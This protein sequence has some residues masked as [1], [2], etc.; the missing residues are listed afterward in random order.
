MDK[1]IGVRADGWRFLA[2]RWVFPVGRTDGT[3]AFVLN[4]WSGLALA[5][6]LY[7]HLGVL[8]MIAVSPNAYDRFLDLA[9]SPLGLA[10]DVVVIFLI[11]FHGL[12]GL[13]IIYATVAGHI[14]RHR[15]QFWAVVALS[16]LLTLY[17]AVLIF[18]FE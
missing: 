5:I 1:P 3:W 8:T 17:S 11:L 12:N 16:L 10:S 13:R 14:E 9:G 18:S 15:A 7:A 6:Y 2:R 4:R